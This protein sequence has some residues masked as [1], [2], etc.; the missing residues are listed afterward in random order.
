[1]HPKYF[2]A[3]FLF[4]LLA[5]TLFAAAP[6][7]Y[8]NPGGPMGDPALLRKTTGEAVAVE[9]RYYLFFTGEAP[10]PHSFVARSTTDFITWKDEGVIF[11][12]KGT[13]ARSAYWA[14]EAYE[15]GGKF[16]LFF[17]AQNSDL[18]WTKEEHFNIGIA[19]AEKPAGPYKLLVDRPIFEPGYPIIDANLYI[20][21]DG[22]PYLTYSRCCYLHPVESELADLA[23]KNGWFDTIEESW[24][25]GVKLTKDFMNVDGEPVLLLRPPVKLDD[26]Q[27]EWESRS[28]TS[29]EVNRRW[30]EGST[31]FKHAGKYYLM[32]SGNSFTGDNY[33]VGYAVSDKPLGPYQKADNNP[34]LEKNTPTGGTVRGT[35]HNNVFFSPDRSEMFCVYHG[36]TEGDARRLFIDRMTIDEHGVLRVQGPTTTPQPVPQWKNA[37]KKF[38]LSK[39]GEAACTIVIPSNPTPVEKTAAKELKE[40]LD[41]VT[42][43]N[44]SIRGEH[45]YTVARPAIYVG[46]TIHVDVSK[47]PYDG[48]VIKTTDKGLILTGHPQRG[49]L[50]AVYSFL[51]DAVGVRWWTSTESFIPKKPTLEIPEQNVEYAPKL[52]YREAYYKDAFNGVFASRMKCNGSSNEITS[53]YGGHHRFFHF[54]HSFFPL[55]PPE[56][57][58][59]KHPEW[60]SEIDGVR[61]HEHAQLCLANDEMRA[62][63]TKNALE[64]LRKRPDCKFISISQN[65]WYGFCTCPKC[66]TVDD[67]EGSQAGT[68]IRFVNKVAEDIEKEFPDVWVETLAYQYTRKPPK[69]V[70]PRKNV[71]VRL[72]TIECSFVQPL[73][74]GER[75]KAFRDDI[76]GWSK[77]ADNLFIWD[78]TV[79]FTAYMLPHPNHRVLGP[80][81]KFFVANNAIGLFEQGDAHCTAGDFVRMKNWVLSKLMWNSE[82]DAEKLYDEFI[83]GYYGPD[84]ARIVKE[85]LKLIHDRAEKS[86]V[87]LKCFMNS[88]GGWLDAETMVKAH[89]VLDMAVLFMKGEV[90]K[91][92]NRFN[93]LRRDKMPIDLVV[94]RNYH[95]LRRQHELGKIKFQYP[96]P[97]KL[98]DDF[99]VRCK[100]FGVTSYDEWG[101]QV[102]LDSVLDGLKQKFG[103]PAP[104][105][106]FCKDLPKDTW[107]DIQ[108]FEFS[109]HKPGQWT[110]RIEDEKAS[111]GRAVK[112]PGDHFEWATSYNFDDSL[113]SL[114]GEMPTYRLYAAVRCDAKTSDGPAMTLGVYDYKE[115]KSVAH[116]SVS[117]SEITGPDYRWI[118][119]GFLPLRP[120]HNFWFAPPKRPGEVDAV[121]IDRIV[122]VRE[123]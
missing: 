90:L 112:M 95:T 79:N 24:V 11:D 18:P 27:A 76:E 123:K 28:V 9:G 110:F 87:Y 2:C 14:P 41:A 44:F 85:Y 96:E 84:D 94:L 48:I 45:E 114:N 3:A 92:E 98:L 56:K 103:P 65:D 72:C 93:L 119:L 5:T 86:K 32:Y 49:P 63:L 111:N 51:E 83:E 106:E 46:D 101:G 71:V 70:K 73:G 61:K 35:G 120:G 82:L 62:E 57:Y 107:I 88:T 31:L 118:D 91:D 105:P 6:T 66:K 67:E 15:I 39:D 100:E 23:K 58:F 89:L 1:M 108:N 12:G 20:D 55:L 25:Y 78:Y 4:V 10:N 117:V 77:I 36:R 68:L 8:V 109:A 75:N 47:I 97:E 19:V 121:Y 113:T 53:E 116:K 60:Y 80:N 37:K 16:Y 38:R 54:V 17:S 50:Y 59:E 21:D 22:T 42:G 81:V 34:V 122:I 102:K 99:I 69:H 52:I 26:K 7:T 30:T 13:W 29:R 33:A 104:A 43:G 74:E 40:H 64:G 115:K